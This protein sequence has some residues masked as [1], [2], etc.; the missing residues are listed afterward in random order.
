MTA[1]V[2]IVINHPVRTARTPAEPF[3]V[4]PYDEPIVDAMNLGITRGDGIFETVGIHDGKVH[5][6]EAHLRRFAR[7]AALLDLPDPDPEAY[8]DA[9]ELGIELL[10]DHAADAYAKYVLTRGI[11]S[12]DSNAFGYVFLDVNP[13]W[14]R[15][16]T[17]GI[18]VVTLSR[19]YALD[20]Q[21]TSPWLLQ[22]AKTLSYAVNRAVLREAERR[23]AEDVI[24][25]TTDGYALEGPTSSLL[26]R[27]GD[28][29]V[30]PTPEFGVLHGT[31]QQGAYTWLEAQGHFTEYRPVRVDELDA[32]DHLWMTN[33]QRLAVPIRRLDD[34]DRAVDRSFTES[35][36]AYL[37]NRSS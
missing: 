4:V 13:D 9:V 23:G 12:R 15:E 1:P 37:L 33:S 11:E 21:Q 17:E 22:G 25:T 28:H 5:E 27:F 20:V 31:G 3:R 8:R 30:T 24:F 32:A 19:G 2:L 29:F 34:V 35:L 14:M 26:L 18:T 6:V 16:R 10:E 36:N 7:S